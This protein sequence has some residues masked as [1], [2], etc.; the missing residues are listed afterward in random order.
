MGRARSVSLSK[1]AGNSIQ[2]V[3]E[4]SKD[5]LKEAIRELSA[6]P[7]LGKT[8]LIESEGLRSYQIGW[9]RIICRITC[10]LIEV[11]YLEHPEDIY[12]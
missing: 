2:E 8:L 10:D 3:D 4:R 7:S 1:R 9:F 6:N 12:R 5:Y 11:V